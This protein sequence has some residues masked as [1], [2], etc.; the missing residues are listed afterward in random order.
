MKD[1]GSAGGVT[2][3]WSQIQVVFTSSK[4]DKNQLLEEIAQEEK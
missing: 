1:K 4:E 2:G 3:D